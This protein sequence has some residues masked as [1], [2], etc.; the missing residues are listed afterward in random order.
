MKAVT[1]VHSSPTEP[2]RLPTDACGGPAVVVH[3]VAVRSKLPFKKKVHENKRR[4]KGAPKEEAVP[5]NV[6]NNNSPVEAK[7]GKRPDKAVVAAKS[8]KPKKTVVVVASDP[9]TAAGAAAAVVGEDPLGKVRNWLIN[10]HNLEDAG[11]LKKSKSSP[12]GFDLS[13]PTGQNRAS[14]RPTAAPPVKSAPAVDAAAKKAKCKDRVKLQLVYKPPFK[15]SVKLGKNKNEISSHL[16]KDKRPEAVKQRA[17]LLV[18]A[19]R[20]RSQ[21]ASKES[22][23]AAPS[24]EKAA[25]PEVAKMEEA[26]K[27]EYKRS[28][29]APQPEP[30]YQNTAFEATAAWD[31]KQGGLGERCY[32]N[33]FGDSTKNGLD[34]GAEGR[35]RVSR[36]ASLSMG[37][38]RRD[39]SSDGRQHSA[40]SKAAQQPK[41]A[42]GKRRNSCDTGRSSKPADVRRQLS[43]EPEKASLKRT[44]SGELLKRANAQRVSVG[45]TSRRQ[46]NPV[47]IAT[48]SKP[49]RLKFGELEELPKSKGA[50][51][52]DTGGQSRSRQSRVRRSMSGNEA[53]HDADKFKR[54]SLQNVDLSRLTPP[55]ADEARSV[56]PTA[57]FESV[58][59]PFRPVE[60]TSEIPSD[61]EVL[62][63]E[64]ENT[65]DGGR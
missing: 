16:I 23:T 52:A 49:V 44:S 32:A 10:S 15:F 56:F 30:L 65:V 7:K 29:S 64:S 27:A 46:P 55:R 22:T 37:V 2:V 4:S 35:G 31:E 38:K 61:L 39:S 60:M 48:S 14:K 3:P 1:V 26:P 53:S 62:L 33:V 41:G 12:A 9:K 25:V 28:I 20:I 17:A 47:L 8:K 36:N 45:P 50:A 34:A 43:D 59:L 58:E 54:Y 11:S 57:S 42:A 18:R 63:S 13:D 40:A 24:K 21:P 5:H 19:D 6:N 51:K